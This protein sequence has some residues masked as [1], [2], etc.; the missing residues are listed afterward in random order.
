MT[1][2]VVGSRADK[3]AQAKKGIS[4]FAK[5]PTG[6]ATIIG[7]GAVTGKAI[8]KNLDPR[9]LRPPTVKGGRTGRR[10]AKS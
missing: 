4:N 3:I 5:T 1:P 9:K 8:E 10:S 7:G 2:T 6:A